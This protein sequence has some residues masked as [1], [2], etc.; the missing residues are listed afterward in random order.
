M[1]VNDGFSFSSCRKSS[2]GLTNIAVV[3]IDNI[4]VASL[5]PAMDEENEN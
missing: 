3:W 2:C 5:E 1:R 4:I